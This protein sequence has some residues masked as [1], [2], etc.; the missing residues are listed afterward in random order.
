MRQLTIINGVR[1]G[2]RFVE[3]NGLQAHT[4]NLE[5]IRAMVATPEVSLEGSPVRPINDYIERRVVKIVAD[6]LTP[7]FAKGSTVFLVDDV[8]DANS[9]KPI[10]KA[11]RKHDYEVRIANF[12]E[13]AIKNARNLESVAENQILSDKGFNEA[14]DMN[15]TVV[16]GDVQSMAGALLKAIQ[17]V[18]PGDRV[19]FLGDLFDRGDNPVSVLVQVNLLINAGQNEVVLIEGNHDAHLRDLL[20]GTAPS[21]GWTKAGTRDTL[22]KLTSGGVSRRTIKSIIDRMKPAF[23]L[24]HGD[25]KILFTHAGVNRMPT[26]LTSVH[27]LYTGTAPKNAQ[28]VGKS[29][30]APDVISQLYIPGVVQIHG[31]RNGMTLEEARNPKYSDSHF[32]LEGKVEKGGF[33][34]VAIIEDGKIEVRHF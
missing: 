7:R 4:V 9:L 29:S 2:E 22:N 27:H 31:H 32:V 21:H 1:Q 18:N 17:I 13:T 34:P 5:D 30:Y 25:M 26:V 3:D 10:I 24:G 19:V 14:T 23:V 28:Q 33:L 6:I 12:S 20:N 11:A 8:R 16:I 15:R